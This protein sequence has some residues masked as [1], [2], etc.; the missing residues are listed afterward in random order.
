MLM[1]DECRTT[2][3]AGARRVQYGVGFTTVETEDN[4][5][6]L[7][8]FVTTIFTDGDVFIENRRSEVTSAGESGS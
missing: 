2:H 6:V 7:E 5:E 8:H 1:Y 3:H 4:G